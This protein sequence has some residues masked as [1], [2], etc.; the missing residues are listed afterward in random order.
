MHLLSFFLGMSVSIE[1]II[2]GLSGG[3]E[4][5]PSG[6]L[7]ESLRKKETSQAGQIWGM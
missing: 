7:K 3:K 6:I 5:F 2:W 1:T 4:V